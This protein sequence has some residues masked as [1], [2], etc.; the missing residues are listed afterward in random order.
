MKKFLFLALSLLSL[1]ACTPTQETRGNLVDPDRM[2]EIV[3]GISTRQNVLQTLGSPTTVAPFD[4]NVWYY[5]GQKTE[6]SG[7][8]DPKVVEQKVVAVAFNPEGIVDV[9][10]P[11]D[12]SQINVPIARRKTPT[13]GNE[14]TILQQLMGNI[15]RFNKGADKSPDR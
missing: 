15:G 11:I 13:G 5:I 3:P 2:A 6:Q 9:I 4:E 14:V 12:A 10:Q 1:A 8:F 7:V